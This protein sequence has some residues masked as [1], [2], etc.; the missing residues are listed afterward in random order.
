M[1]ASI[2]FW[3]EKRESY[4]HRSNG[5]LKT[6]PKIDVLLSN[7]LPRYLSLLLRSWGHVAPLDPRRMLIGGWL[8]IYTIQRQ[9]SIHQALSTASNV[10]NLKKA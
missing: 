6:I 5:P 8:T 10:D 4:G 7:S 9:I 2:V 1:I 3:E